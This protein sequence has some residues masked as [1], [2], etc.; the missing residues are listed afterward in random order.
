MT[1]CSYDVGL[2]LYY[3]VLPEKQE[4]NHVCFNVCAGAVS[5]MGFRI[6]TSKDSDP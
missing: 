3:V 5:V 4:R 6:K 1:S 2:V